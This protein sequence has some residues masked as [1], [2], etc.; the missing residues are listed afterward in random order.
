MARPALD[1]DR[2]TVRLG[3]RERRRQP[4]ADALAGRV[5]VLA[6]RRRTVR[7]AA[8]DPS[9]AMP[10]PA[11][12]TL[13]RTSPVATWRTRTVTRPPSGENLRAFD[14]RFS[15][16][17]SSRG[18]SPKTCGPGPVGRVDRRAP[19]RAGRPAG[20]RRDTTAEARSVAS[21]RR[22]WSR[23]DPDRNRARSRMSPISRCIRSALRS[24]VSSIAVRCSS[25]GWEL[26]SSSRP[27]LVRTTVSGVRSSCAMVDSRSVRRRSTSW[28]TAD[29][30]VRQAAIRRPAGRGSSARTCDPRRGRRGRARARPA[31]RAGPRRCRRAGRRRDRRS[32]VRGRAALATGA[33]RRSAAR[34][35]GDPSATEDVTHAGYGAS[36]RGTSRPDP[37][38][39]TDP[40]IRPGRRLDRQRI[41]RVHDARA[42]SRTSYEHE[43]GP[44]TTQPAQ[45]N[46]RPTWNSG[47]PAISSSQVTQLSV[48]GRGRSWRPRS[49]AWIHA[50]RTLGTS[51]EARRER[52]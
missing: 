8:P 24:M 49:A 42:S 37:E 1:L 40:T 28:R 18:R 7:T 17:R 38:R 6:R 52:G 27:V 23:M 33:I 50:P 10:G 25:V 9:A 13:Q 14:T 31:R 48:H 36:D 3:D 19:G 51:P 44:P 21:N 26:G 34:L 5:L 39:G 22:S 11:S 29:A 45:Q 2:A 46:G 15:R 32:A 35:S 12:I 20:G 16:A 30:S 43:H 4:E 41:G 47:R